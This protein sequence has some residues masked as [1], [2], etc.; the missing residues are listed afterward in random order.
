MMAKTTSETQNSNAE[1][2][3]DRYA[4]W[5]DDGTYHSMDV[6]GTPIDGAN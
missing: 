3:I 2:G 4:W 5:W 6:S 1:S